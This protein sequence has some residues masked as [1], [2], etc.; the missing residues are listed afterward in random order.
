MKKLINWITQ[1]DKVF[2]RSDKIIV[3][4][5]LSFAAVLC[6]GLVLAS[7]WYVTL[8]L[9]IVALFI[10]L[11]IGVFSLIDKHV[12]KDIN[13]TKSEM[14]QIAHDNLKSAHFIRKEYGNTE[15]APAIIQHN[16]KMAHSRDV[17]ITFRIILTLKKITKSIR[18]LFLK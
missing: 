15:Q 9:L 17:Q 6:I 2:K 7:E 3:T 14:R 8:W 11:L 5:G 18:W 10:G 4:L 12:I 13:L 16:R 1:E